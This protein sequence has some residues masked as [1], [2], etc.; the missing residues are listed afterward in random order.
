MQGDRGTDLRALVEHIP[1]ALFRRAADPPWRFE[2]V[3]DAIVAITGRRSEDLVVPGGLADPLLP[4]AEDLP[5]VTQAIRDAVATKE[6][7]ALEYRVK[8]ADGTTRWIQD[9]GRPVDDGDGR[10]VWIVGVLVDIT[11]RM[12]RERALLVRQAGLD[13]LFDSTPDHIYFKDTESRFTLISPALATAFGLSDPSEAVGKTDAD[14]FLA[15]HARAAL[16]DEREIMRTGLHLVDREESETW[17][18]GSRTWVSTTKLAH[19]DV[20]GNVIGTFGIS[21][22]ITGRR[23]AEAALAESEERLQ[24]VLRGSNDGWWIPG[25]RGGH[26][27]L[28][29]ALVADDRVRGRRPAGR[30]RAP[31]QAHAP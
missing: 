30:A 22:D 3:S 29:P 19:R 4:V 13:A 26:R 18:D 14:F 5:H 8:H 24:L 20:D 11:A 21:R 28:L 12:Q 31:A 10:S 16:E 15:D 27:L 25:S 7:Y 9:L 2:F 23:Q 17:P 6:P 1:G